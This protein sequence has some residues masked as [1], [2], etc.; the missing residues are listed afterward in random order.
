[1]TCKR[2][3]AIQTN[4]GCVVKFV[5]LTIFVA[6]PG[7]VSTSRV[8]RS[9]AGEEQSG[10]GGGGGGAPW[11]LPVTPALLGIRT[12]ACN[13]RKPCDAQG[14]TEPRVD[15]SSAREGGRRN[16][17]RPLEADGLRVRSA[18]RTVGRTSGQW[19]SCVLH[20][21]WL[22]HVCAWPSDSPTLSGNA[23]DPSRAAGPEHRAVVK[24]GQEPR[25]SQEPRHRG[26]VWTG[27]TPQSG[28]EQLDRTRWTS[29]TGI[30]WITALTSP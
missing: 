6:G 18:L 25:H 29:A 22:Q 10:A 14:H 8:A 1:M 9:S 11:G 27:A 30:A 7:C 23:D 16:A 24:S 28:P 3:T 4:K 2:L 15:A 20:A 21:S 17:T 13:K 19:A 26:Q 12:T 5:Q